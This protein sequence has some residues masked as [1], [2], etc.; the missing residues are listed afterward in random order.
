MMSPSR[1]L[2]SVY[3]PSVSLSE[4]LTI[5]FHS[6]F[7]LRPFCFSHSAKIMIPLFPLLSPICSLSN[8]QH[9]KQRLQKVH[10]MNIICVLAANTE[11]VGM[12]R[13]I[14]HPINIA[15]GTTDPG[16]WLFNLTYLSS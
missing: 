6:I 13:H 7:L 15:R 4:T 5:P 11:L 1:S 3:Q 2:Q 12:H 9:F 8:N 16:Y 10:G 14:I